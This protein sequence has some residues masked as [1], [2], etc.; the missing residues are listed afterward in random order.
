MMI[1]FKV[2]VNRYT[3]LIGILVGLY[4]KMAHKPRAKHNMSETTKTN[5]KRKRLESKIDVNEIIQVEDDKDVLR[6]ESMT[7]CCNA[8]SD[9]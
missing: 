8:N 4:I 5:L 2:F 6:S 7:E 1:L 3:I 9:I